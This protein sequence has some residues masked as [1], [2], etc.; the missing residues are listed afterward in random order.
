MLSIKSSCSSSVFT[1]FM[2][3]VL[4]SLVVMVTPSASLRPVLNTE[5]DAMNLN[6]QGRDEF[7]NLEMEIA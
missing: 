6:F 7:L 4:I 2:R 5:F 3:S 1:K